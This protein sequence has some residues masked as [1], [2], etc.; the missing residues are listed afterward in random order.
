MEIAAMKQLAMRQLQEDVDDVSE[1]DDLLSAYID[2]GYIELM[3]VRKRGT[4]GEIKSITEGNELPERYHLALVDYATYR[5]L[6]IGNAQKQQRAQFFLSRF[7]NAKNA[8]PSECDE[9]AEIGSEELGIVG[10]GGNWK[11][12]GLYNR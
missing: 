8:M 12:T 6:S 5:V 1:Y 7:L 10:N 4:A 2:D 3:T 9:L 11:F